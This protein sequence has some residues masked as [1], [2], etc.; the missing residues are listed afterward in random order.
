STVGKAGLRQVAELSLQKAHYAAERI[1]ALPGYSVANS[2]SF[3][4]EFVVRGPVPV[5][6]IKAR[7][8]SDNVLAGFALGSAYPELND[9]LLV[10]CTENNTREEIDRLVDGL[11]ALR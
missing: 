4:N 2:A 11:G 7:L 9:A 3:F 5:E 8:A 1:G 6:Q 10:C